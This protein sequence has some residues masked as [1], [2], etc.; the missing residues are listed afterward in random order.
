MLP[1]DAIIIQGLKGNGKERRR[2]EEVLYQAYEYFIKEGSREYRLTHE[3]S[4]SAYHD[5]F[6]SAV[7]NIVNSRFDGNS[8]LKTYLY[9]IF[10][11]KCIDLVRK[12]ATNKNEVHRASPLPDM[13]NLLP[14]GA[15]SIVEGMMTRE[16]KEKVKAQLESIGE[17]CKEI[18][19]LYEEGF[20]DKEIAEQLT[21]NNSAVAK[22]TRLRCLD[23][24]KAKVI[25]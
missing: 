1:Q 23:K 9:K 2:Q 19:L 11:N 8:S 10:S 17:K 15:K 18:L 25:G 6:T 21:Y 3:D 7:D 22:T 4:A 20:T 24:L 12:N 16:L 14:D 5:A 13:L